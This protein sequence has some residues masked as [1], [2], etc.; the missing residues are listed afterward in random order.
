M[1]KLFRQLVPAVMLE[2]NGVTTCREKRVGRNNLKKEKK[3]GN[4]GNSVCSC[5]SLK[6][7]PNFTKSLRRDKLIKA[8]WWAAFLW[9][10]GRFIYVFVVQLCAQ[11]SRGR[12][13]LAVNCSITYS[14]R[15]S[16]EEK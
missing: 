1:N 16:S 6:A 15:I 5:T 9:Y 4:G 10:G 2:K 14:T 13:W 12:S 11:L 3:K 8:N 7:C